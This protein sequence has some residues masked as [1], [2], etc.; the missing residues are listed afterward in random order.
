MNLRTVLFLP[1]A[2]VVASTP[3]AVSAQD[4]GQAAAVDEIFA[5]WASES[6]AGCVV[7]VSRWGETVLESAYGMAELEHGRWNV[8]RLRNGWR[9]GKTRDDARKIHDCLLPWSAPGL[10]NVRHYDRN[11]VRQ[12]PE[13]LAAA[14]L[15][16]RRRDA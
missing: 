7:G 3:I 4:T 6:S 8:E 9:P 15:E 1:I 10:D 14:G 5:E 2:V 13:I 11:A 12:F 16:V